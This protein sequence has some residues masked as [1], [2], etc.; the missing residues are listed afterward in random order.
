MA[1]HFGFEGIDRVLDATLTN[2]LCIRVTWDDDWWD[3]L[4][5]LESYPKRVPGGYVCTECDPAT[6]ATFSTREALWAD[7]LFEPF[8]TWANEDL[9]PAKAL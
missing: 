4:T 5:C 9:A 6:R 2:E 3:M 1:L 8:M 7:E